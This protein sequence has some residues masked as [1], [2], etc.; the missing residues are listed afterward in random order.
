MQ[1]CNIL[2]EA[3]IWFPARVM[4]RGLPVSRLQHGRARRNGTGPFSAEQETKVSNGNRSKY[5]FRN[6]PLER[7]IGPFETYATVKKPVRMGFQR[8]SS[9]GDPC[10]L[11]LVPRSHP[12]PPIENLPRASPS[13]TCLRH[14]R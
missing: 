9:P 12:S 4:T 13:L 2:P 3:V 1:D 11:R 6:G 14:L 5:N 7:G 10:L 8:T